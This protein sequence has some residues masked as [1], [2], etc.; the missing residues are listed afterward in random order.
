MM[1]E[2]KSDEQWREE[3]TDEQYHV[4]REKGTERPFTG[5]Y[6]FFEKEG[7]FHCVCCGEPL[8]DSTV[9]FDAGCGWPSFYQTIDSDAITLQ[10]DKSLGMERTEVLCS[11]CGAH[12]GHVFPD[13]PEPTGLRYCI[14][15]V[16]MKFKDR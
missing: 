9:K 13:G 11:N 12:L 5:E 16:A 4:C 10:E 15:S 7:I 14:N 3:L 6:N 2:K 1:K 8:F